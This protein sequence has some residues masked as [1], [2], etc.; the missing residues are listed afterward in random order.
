VHAGRIRGKGRE[1]AAAEREELHVGRGE[2]R[3]SS[4]GA[5][6]EEREF[7]EDMTDADTRDERVVDEHVGASVDDDETFLRELTLP[8][9]HSTGADADRRAETR[10]RAQF[11]CAAS[12]EQLYLRHPGPAPLLVSVNKKHARSVRGRV[13]WTFDGRLIGPYARG[14]GSRGT[15]E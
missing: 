4:G 12:V 15:T 2:N 14:I 8:A 6:S 7:T 9:E 13:Q 11:A 3:R 5:A 1:L 10:K